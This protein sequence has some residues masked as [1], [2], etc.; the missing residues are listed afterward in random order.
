[1]VFTEAYSSHRR[2]KCYL[3][4]N[5]HYVILVILVPPFKDEA[6]TTLFKDPVRTALKV[7]LISV[8]KTNHFMSYVA[9]VAV[10]SQINTKH[11]NTLWGR[12]YDC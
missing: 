10:C 1:M 9:E 8:L 5:E 3:L 2:K 12:A 4:N 11:I 7:F 6:Q